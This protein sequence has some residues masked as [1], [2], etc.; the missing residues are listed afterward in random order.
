MRYPGD[1]HVLP[2]FGP[3]RWAPYL[4]GKFYWKKYQNARSFFLSHTTEL[5]QQKQWDAVS[6]STAKIYPS[7]KYN[8]F[9]SFIIDQSWN[10]LQLKNIVLSFHPPFQPITALFTI[11]GLWPV[12]LPLARGKLVCE[13]YFHLTVSITVVRSNKA[14]KTPKNTPPPPT[15]KKKK[16]KPPPN[17]TKPFSYILAMS[18]NARKTFR[19]LTASW[20]GARAH[21]PPPRVR[22]WH[23]ARIH[24]VIGSTDRQLF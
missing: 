1:R 21:S 7:N 6:K 18:Y 3:W 13:F 8:I 20:R 14:P 22:Q 17:H 12:G 19:T 9:P 23:C 10:T 2:L 4:R 5:N 11:T 15:Q 16:P 24:T